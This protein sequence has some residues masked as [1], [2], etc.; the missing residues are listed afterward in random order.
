MKC[1]QFRLYGQSAFKNAKA[2]F[3]KKISLKLGGVGT[4]NWLGFEIFIFVLGLPGGA[5]S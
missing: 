4:N 5:G 3:K 2:H 1:T